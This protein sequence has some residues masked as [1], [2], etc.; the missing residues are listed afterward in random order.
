MNE[1]DAADTSHP[2]VCPVCLRLVVGPPESHTC[3]RDGDETAEGDLTIEPLSRTTNLTGE[4]QHSPSPTLPDRAPSFSEST[5]RLLERAALD[6]AGSPPDMATTIR[7][8]DGVRNR[9][10]RTIEG[11][12]SRNLEPEKLA[13]TRIGD[14]Q[15]IEV[16]GVGGMGIVYKARQLSLNRLVAL[17]TIGSRLL[18]S[19][20]L[21]ARF[22]SEATAVAALQH[23][24]IVP[25]YEVGHD[26]ELHYFSMRLVEGGNLSN[27]IEKGP[28]RFGFKGGPRESARLVMTLARAIDAAHRHGVLHRDLKPANVLLN[29]SGEPLIADF[30][31]AKRLDDDSNLTRTGDIIGSPSYMAPEQ[32]SGDAAATT[33]S[34]DVYSLGAILYEMLTGRPPFRGGNLMETIRQ[35]KE[36]EVRPPRE[37]V[38]ALPRD[39]DTICLKCLQKDPARRYTSADQL[40]ADL[41]RWLRGEPIRARKIG[42]LEYALMWARR[43]PAPAALAALVAAIAF[44]GF[45]LA[46]VLLKRTEA[47]LSS[48]A[49]ARQKVEI[50]DY[51]NRISLVEQNLILNHLAPV[52]ELLRNCAKE[53][54]GWEWNYLSRWFRESPYQ[55]P[56]LPMLGREVAWSTDGK[57]L[58]A[59]YADGAVRLYSRDSDGR[60]GAKPKLT[61]LAHTN[62][63]L[64]VRFLA[65]GRHLISLGQDGLIKVWD[66][67]AEP[68]ANGSLT[69][70]ARTFPSGSSRPTCLSTSRD[71]GLLAVGYADGT[72][73]V[74]EFHSGKVL[75]TI[76]AHQMSISAVEFNPD[77]TKLATGAD[78]ATAKVWDVASGKQLLLFSE[79][80]APVDGL[81]WDPTG[82]LI[83]S[84]SMDTVMRLWEAET[85]AVLLTCKGHNAPIF[86]LAFSPDGTRIATPSMDKTVKLWETKSGREVITLR[87]HGGPVFQA[88]FSA[89]G[90]TLATVG[91]DGVKIWDA[92]AVANLAGQERITYRGHGAWAFDASFQPQ[93][94]LV[95]SVSGD[96]TVH[97]WDPKD[98]SLVRQFGNHLAPVFNVAFR[99]DG[100]AAATCD[101]SGTTLIWEVSTGKLLRTLHSDEQT[102]HVTWSPD[103]RLLLTGG[104]DDG[105]LRLWNPEDGTL[106]RKFA[107]H[108][109]WVW[110]AVFSPDGKR[111]ASGSFDSTVRLWDVESGKE[112]FALQGHKGLVRSV[113]FHPDGKK[114]AS[115]GDRTLKIWDLESRKEIASLS[116]DGA[117]L[118]IVTFTPDGN[119]LAGGSE[120]GRILL[121]STRDWN[122]LHT[123]RGHT[124]LVH[125]LEFDRDGKRLISASW[126]STIRIWDLP[127][128]TR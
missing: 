13:G 88:E 77:A 91:T 89:D 39:L 24:N 53:L 52:D 92:T 87:G 81:A 17:K 65:D 37:L 82:R 94:E 122:P 108:R 114:L 48:E 67:T 104:S 19:E 107:G 98:G 78:D 69:V 110:S 116:D 23:P 83:A 5:V 93:G 47:A 102:Y 3:D 6:G 59:T 31:L 4:P 101:A 50:N 62:M 40:A 71:G 126:D 120:N 54:R 57:S 97:L 27:A 75:K 12:L 76:P 61:I 11:F 70:A 14:Y 106:L 58:A 121:W 20:Q 30:G 18:H 105:V 84:A 35:V 10:E 115:A 64:A 100:K 74:Y 86:G 33:V 22:V 66:L 79:H 99:K 117:D 113:A 49:A 103:G 21:I 46:L 2:M 125:G 36:V 123:F 43:R 45:P 73:T 9:E 63:G 28:D 1:R 42:K 55:I 32:A 8:G 7:D 16:I 41:E 72:L 44:I 38:P 118:Q 51:F 34:V 85:G 15:L 127:A 95:A 56:G 29:E 112:L 119:I 90:Q 96:R 68:D 26:D 60:F 109:S 25:I 111:I 128:A 80:M 124:A